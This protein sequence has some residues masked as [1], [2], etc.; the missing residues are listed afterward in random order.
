MI[1]DLAVAG[2]IEGVGCT[3]RHLLEHL[4]EEHGEAGGGF[5][6]VLEFENYGVKRRRV[7]VY[8]GDL[9]GEPGAVNAVV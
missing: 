6:K 8:V 7:S 2:W 1:A 4:G 3:A 9:F 5:D